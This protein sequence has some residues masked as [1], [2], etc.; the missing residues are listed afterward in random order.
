[1]NSFVRSR[2][3]VLPREKKKKTGDRKRKENFCLWCN[4][5]L[6]KTSTLAGESDEKKK[7]TNCQSVLFASLTPATNSPQ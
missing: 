5:F 1:M 2:K 3:C 7:V 6:H 4:P